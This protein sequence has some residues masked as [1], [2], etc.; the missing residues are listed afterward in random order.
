MQLL[1]RDGEHTVASSIKWEGG[2]TGELL[3]PNSAPCRAIPK[4]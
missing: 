3:L 1:S 4:P 2:Q